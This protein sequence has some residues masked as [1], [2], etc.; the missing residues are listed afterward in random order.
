MA[1]PHLQ[2]IHLS[3]IFPCFVGGAVCSCGRGRASAKL[4]SS[5]FILRSDR[6]GS[7]TDADTPSKHAH[8]HQELRSAQPN[9]PD[10][11]EPDSTELDSTELDSTELDS[12]GLDRTELNSTQPPVRSGTHTCTQKGAWSSTPNEQNRQ[13]I[14]IPLYVYMML[15]LWGSG[16]WLVAAG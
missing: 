11:T 6:V 8:Q 2:H 9:Q 1:Y 7:R 12:T 5:S 10:P 4:V 16:C 13:T 15:D 14:H 3:T